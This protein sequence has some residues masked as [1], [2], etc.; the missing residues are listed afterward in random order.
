VVGLIVLV[1]TRRVDVRGL[2]RALRRGT[3]IFS[4]HVLYNA[5]L[6]HMS[7]IY[8]NLITREMPISRRRPFR[9]QLMVALLLHSMTLPK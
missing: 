5:H 9:D 1:I 6:E 8:T 4:P 7:L 2:I 3:A